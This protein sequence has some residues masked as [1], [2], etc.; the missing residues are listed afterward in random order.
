MSPV[1]P[2]LLTLVGLAAIAALG[3]VGVPAL[4]ARSAAAQGELPLT[5]KLS[6]EMI[7]YFG[8]Q[9][10]YDRPSIAALQQCAAQ[11]AC[12]ASDSAS[13][14][15]LDSTGVAMAAFNASAT[16][17]IERV[18]HAR[19]TRTD[20]RVTQVMRVRRYSQD[21]QGRLTMTGVD[22]LVQRTTAGGRATPGTL[23]R[24][25][26]YEGVRYLPNDTTYVWPITGLVV[27]EEGMS[28]DDMLP[29]T[30]YNAA[31]SFDGSPT[32]TILTSGG[33]THRADLKRRVL[34][35]VLPER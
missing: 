28:N 26:R 16:R 22:S 35:T 17:T 32:A 1:K 3:F 7:G 4:S 34:E 5:A 21:A 9:A 14:R 20:G 18:T 11:P 13:I 23:A 25:H 24:I 29:R 31:V 15:F 19:T 30:R 27:M 10:G 2:A 8:L 12:G 6:D 33:L